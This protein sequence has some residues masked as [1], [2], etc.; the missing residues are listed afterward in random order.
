MPSYSF[1]GEES[2]RFARFA[3]ACLALE[4]E[5]L[6]EVVGREPLTSRPVNIVG[7]LTDACLDGYMRYIVII[8]NQSGIVYWVGGSNSTRSIA[9]KSIA[10]ELSDLSASNLIGHGNETP[11]PIPRIRR[12]HSEQDETLW[13]IE[14]SIYQKDAKNLTFLLESLLSDN[15]SVSLESALTLRA[16]AGFIAESGRRQQTAEDAVLASIH[17]IESW[18]TKAALVEDLG[19][20]GTGSAVLPLSSLLASKD[21]HD[22]VRWAA[23]ISLGRLPEVEPLTSLVSGLSSSHEWTQAAT[24]LSCARQ[25]SKESAEMEALFASYLGAGHSPIMNRYACLGLSKLSSHT[26]ATVTALSGVLGDDDLPIGVRGYAAL[27]ISVGLS[28]VSPRAISDIGEILGR[29]SR[30]PAIDTKEPEAIWGIEFLAELASLLE[31]NEVSTTLHSVLAEHFDDWRSDYYTCMKF[32][33]KAEASVRRGLGDEAIVSY[34]RAISELR[35]ILVPSRSH[36]LPPEAR[37]TIEFRLDVVSSRLKLQSLLGSWLESTNR[38]DLPTISEALRP[39]KETYRRYSTLGPDIGPDRQLI[40][41]E[42]AYL[43][44]TTDL[45]EVISALIDLDGTV[46]QLSNPDAELRQLLISVQLISESVESLEKKF[47]GS[48]AQSLTSLIKTI[49]LSLQ[50]MEEGIKSATLELPDKLR[51]ARKAI[52]QV[53]SSL[54]RAS[55]P[56]PARACP[57]YGLGRAS[58]TFRTDGILGKGT[59]EDPLRFPKGAPAVLLARVRIFEM[60]P[61]GSTTVRL[62][63]TFGGYEGSQNVPI[64]EDQYIC[65]INIKEAIP[66]YAAIPLDCSLMFHAR[67]CQQQ[68]DQR[69]VFLIS[70]K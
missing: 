20:F 65:T 30:F 67:D 42:I 31:L 47:V 40:A 57:V 9:T 36:E 33:E 63:H 26:E 35:P 64:V 27:A 11:L 1:T 69:R 44:N 25:V 10:I 7:T 45:V 58:I 55:W 38:G 46:R 61:G 48:F 6:V 16:F 66:S 34:E 18:E 8:E 50:E 17:K 4:I 54:W 21:E 41:R 2:A 28:Q 29:F 37:A 52:T 24:L 60:A 43:R 32:Y 12:T 15:K 49:R 23:A 68:A 51:L 39:I 56:M 22:H 70:E 13:R 5:A 62:S 53:R 14:N 19:Y 3:Q 59:E